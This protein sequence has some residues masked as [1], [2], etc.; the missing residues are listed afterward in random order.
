MAKNK[1]IDDY[2]SQK[3]PFAQEIFLQL[4]NTIHHAVPEI[5]ES[6]KWRHPCF[7]SNGLLCAIAVFKQHVNFSFFKGKLLNDTAEIFALTENNEL[8]SLKLKTLSDIPTD[9]ILINYLQQANVLNSANKSQKKKTLR[10]DKSSLIIP[11][12]LTA[13]L[14]S[15][16]MAKKTF[17]AFSYSK[18]KDYID[19]L[20]SA[21]RAST[22]SSRL[23][24]AI[25][26]IKEGKSRHWK[27]ENC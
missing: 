21:K 19:W 9:D 25:E 14:A 5:T 7:E 20:T 22:R 4:R 26:W 1:A 17:N 27:Y 23:I 18:Q 11:N 12:D 13:A 6:I 16:P 24:T 15:N 2:I 10:K 3:A 8:A